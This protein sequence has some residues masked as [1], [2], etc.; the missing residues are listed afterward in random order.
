MRINNILILSLITLCSCSE[1]SAYNRNIDLDEQV[2]WYDGIKSNDK[3][4]PWLKI[5]TIRDLKEVLENGNN[6]N[7]LLECEDSS[8]S[9]VKKYYP[10][11]LVKDESARRILIEAGA[12]PNTMRYSEIESREEIEFMVNHGLK[13]NEPNSHGEYPLMNRNIEIIKWLLTH[14]ANPNVRYRDGDTLLH[15]VCGESRGVGPVNDELIDWGYPIVKALLEHGADVNAK[16]REGRTAITLLGPERNYD[17]IRN[18][19]IKYGA[20]KDDIDRFGYRPSAI[21]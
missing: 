7:A 19:L 10:L 13:I 3:N 18:L 21:N 15:A 6:P 20:R 2:R 1:R 9:G 5:N 17:K 12:D 4:A 16:D 8:I 14:G 11:N